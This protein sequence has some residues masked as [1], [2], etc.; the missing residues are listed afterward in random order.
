MSFIDAF[1]GRNSSAPA[2]GRPEEGRRKAGGRPE[3]EGNRGN[4]SVEFQSINLDHNKII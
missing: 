1:K 3:E 2:G 4:T